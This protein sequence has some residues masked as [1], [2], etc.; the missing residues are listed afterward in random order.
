MNAKKE[1]LEVTNK[2]DI[3]CAIIG[4]CSYWLEEKAEDF[5][6]PINYTEE[7]YN[8]FL[9]QLDFNY[10]SGYGSQELEGIIWYKNGSW[11]ERGEYDGSEWW[12]YKKCPEI[13][14]ELL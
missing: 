12:E 11:F 7:Q 1:F 2:D 10:N 5:I 9:D 6:L 8:H 14:K 13:P 3:L 4:N